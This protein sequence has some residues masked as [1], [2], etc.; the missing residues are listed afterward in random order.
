MKLTIVNPMIFY[1]ISVFPLI[2][3]IYLPE[4]SPSSYYLFGVYYH[5]NIYKFADTIYFL[6]AVSLTLIFQVISTILPIKHKIKL[7]FSSLAVNGFLGLF[8][9]FV[10][11]AFILGISDMGIFFNTLYY[12]YISGINGVINK[13]M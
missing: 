10:F 12:V 4:F 8:S 2:F 9:P 6:N 5:D 3:M 1:S 13:W 11:T 7:F